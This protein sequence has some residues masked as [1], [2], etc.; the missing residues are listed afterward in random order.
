MLRHLVVPQPPAVSANSFTR[1]QAVFFALSNRQGDPM[2]KQIPLF[3]DLPTPRGSMYDELEP[4]VDMHL[5]EGVRSCVNH[6]FLLD[7]RT[8]GAGLV[9]SEMACPYHVNGTGYSAPAR[10]TCECP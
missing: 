7:S 6:L 8:F 5:P 3:R 4:K 10:Q 9:R 1:H 2:L